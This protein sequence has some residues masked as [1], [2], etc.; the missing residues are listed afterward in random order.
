MVDE[1]G[2]GSAHEAEEDENY[3]I[4][5]TDMMVGVLFIFIILLMV[6]ALN[7][8]SQTD[9]T[10]DQIKRLQQAE[11]TADDVSS[12]LRALQRTI[13]DDVGAIRNEESVRSQLLQKIKDQLVQNHLVVDV[14]D[15]N[16]VL[17]LRDAAIS[18]APNIYELNAI[19][20][21]NVD[22]IAEVLDSILPSYLT[23]SADRASHLET[24]FIEGHTDETG[25]RDRNWDLSTQRAVRT[26]LGL[27]KA[28]PSLL[29]LRNSAGSPVFSV[30]GYADTRPVPN[31]QVTDYDTQRRIDLRFVMDVDNQKQLDDMKNLTDQMEGE[32]STLRQA[33]D[34]ARR[35]S[36]GTGNGG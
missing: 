4:S 29:D 23:T 32:L 5:M 15:A 30:S 3:F 28:Q 27:A 7:F 18:F 24:V 11:V 8:R 26:Y 20:Q 35:P 1:F 25:I 33:V 17:H 31:S 2:A 9:V 13:N 34:S 6:F 22:K 16:G 14:D 21:Q 12:R 10:A 36:I 19:D